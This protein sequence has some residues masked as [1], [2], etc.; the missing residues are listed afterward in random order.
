[1]IYLVGRVLEPWL[2]KRTLRTALAARPDESPAHDG[3]PGAAAQGPQA[4]TC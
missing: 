4:G 2:L 3:T 1:V